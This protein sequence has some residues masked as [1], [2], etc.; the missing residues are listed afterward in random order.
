MGKQTKQKPPL[1]TDKQEILYVPQISIPYEI[2][3]NE[4]SLLVPHQVDEGMFR[5]RTPINF[6]LDSGRTMLLKT[7]I[8]F[9]L[10]KY[11]DVSPCHGVRQG[12]HVV[13]FPRTII[14]GHLDSI[15]EL[16]VNNGI[17]VLGPRVL[18]ADMINGRELDI[19]IQNIG[20]KMFEIKAGEEI[21][22]IYFTI[23]PISTL[24]LVIE[25]DI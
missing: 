20:K 13:S 24:R 7:G 1:T 25:G 5:I 18:S 19:F 8:K 21:A 22:E 15:F 6:S 11:I 3:R 17:V 9:N 14:H 10:P 12:D 4:S 2:I 23:T 16:L